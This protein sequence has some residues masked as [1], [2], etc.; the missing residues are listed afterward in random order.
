[1][2][3]KILGF[4]LGVAKWSLLLIGA[5]VVA[6]VWWLS[7]GDGKAKPAKEAEPVPVAAVPAASC[8]CSAGAVCL[9]PK[10]GRY[11]LRPDGSKKYGQ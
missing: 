5:L 9:G 7:S 8:D 6:L 1:M 11:C 10:G 3:A 2:L 4:V